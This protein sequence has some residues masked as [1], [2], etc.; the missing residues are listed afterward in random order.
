MSSTLS[1]QD[2]DCDVA[3]I[4]AGLAGLR[5]AERLAAA[6]LNC[7]VLE[8]RDRIGGRLLSQRLDCGATIDLGGQWVGA[9]HQRVLDAARTHGLTLFPTYVEGESVFLID[10]QVR[11]RPGLFPEVDASTQQDID[12]AMEALD[13][14]RRTIDP[15]RPWAAEDARLLD[16]QTYA[17]WLREHV[18][19][20]AARDALAYIALSVFSIEAHDLSLLH[21]LF[22]VS[23]AGGIDNLINTHGGA[24]E[25]RF[26]EGAQQLPIRMA[27]A[28][29]ERVICNAPVVSIEQHAGGVVVHARAL[30]MRA[31]RAIVTL[32]PTL[33]GRLTYAPALPGL[34]DQYTQRAAMGSVIKTM[35]VY[36][37]PFWRDQGLSGL[38]SSQELPISLT[39]D[40]SPADG[41]AGVLVGFLEADAGREWGQRD[42]AQRRG[43][44]VDCMRR[45]FGEGVANYT[46]YVEQDWAQ[47]PYTRGAY[48]GYLPPGAWTSYGRAVREPVGRLHWAGTE[49]ATEWSG[50]MEGALQSGERVAAEVA[51][52]LAND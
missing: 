11:R 42:A 39:Y 41:S 19:S 30:R 46:Q 28:L 50:Y 10:G 7:H 9:M 14:L 44:V 31:R 25:L 40:N 26:V 34:R 5:A 12:R 4:G 33:A 17:S 20:K 43:M 1:I 29:G 23:A 22:Y 6:G 38:A 35:L 45:Y 49:T 24:Q 51:A 21:F 16:G 48:G 32:P 3:V 47:E 2:I 15:Q 18:S 13:Q 27:Q 37:R 36:D 52:A 8:A